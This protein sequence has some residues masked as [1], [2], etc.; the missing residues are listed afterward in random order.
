MQWYDTSI[1]N[2]D[3]TLTSNVTT[4]KLTIMYR[5]SNVK[6]NS[7]VEYFQVLH[8]FPIF[9]QSTSQIPG[10]RVYSQA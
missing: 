3:F 7:I 9:I 6:K 10:I 5:I 8:S 2:F 1:L 4:F